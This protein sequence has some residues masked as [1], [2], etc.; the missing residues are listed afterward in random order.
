MLERIKIKKRIFITIIG[1]LFLGHLV[2]SAILPEMKLNGSFERQKNPTFNL[3][4]WFSGEYQQQ[5]EK[6]LNEN[7]GFRN[8]LVRVNNQIDFYLYR[9]TN[10]YD[11]IIGKEDYLFEEK[12]I[13]GYLGRDCIGRDR[14]NNKAYKIKKVQ[15]TLA[16]LNIDLFIVL[17]AGKGSFY[18]EYIP[19]RY[20][21]EEKE[22]TNYQ[23]WS[24][25]LISHNISFLDFNKWFLEMK[26]TS[27][28]RL[29]P[30]GGIHWS[31]YGELLA[32][33][34]IIKFVDKKLSQPM[35]QIN[36]DTIILTKKMW[37]TDDDIEKGMNLLVDLPD[38]EM[39]YA[40][41][42]FVRSDSGVSPKLLSIADSYYWGMFNFGLSREVFN[43]G[44]FWFYNNQIYPEVN[45][46][47][48]F[49]KDINFQQ[50]IE[51]NKLI[52]LM[53]TEANF[54][55]F[56]FGFIDKAYDIYYGDHST[57]QEYEN[58]IL[59]FIEKIKSDSKWLGYISEKSKV[60]G[61]P[62]EEMIKIDATYMVNSEQEKTDK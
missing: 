8:M 11:V 41:F 9:S 39:A 37:D 44:E 5:K 31:K 2:T 27:R 55:N 26:D 13:L 1:F 45:G 36:F 24:K 34:S 40:Q 33:D 25:E 49:V 46:T 30:K 56:P 57:K 16:K 48:K 47:P 42:K 62:L 19:D 32:A 59:L 18:S 28:Y 54:S 17:A 51:K 3:N 60:R 15:D 12:Y 52:M 22:T 29:F 6:Y 21:K 58:K 10:A 50:E 35:V 43:N 38:L 4:K 23:L 20:F 7:F 61:I 14:I 53:S